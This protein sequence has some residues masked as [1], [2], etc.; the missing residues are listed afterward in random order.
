MVRRFFRILV[1]GYS[2]R[3]EAEEVLAEFRSLGYRGAFAAEKTDTSGHFQSNGFDFTHIMSNQEFESTRVS[4]DEVQSFLEEKDS[5]LADYSLDGKPFS[6]RL[7]ELSR[8]H[9]VNPIVLLAQLQKESSLVARKSPPSD[10]LLRKAMGYAYTDSGSRP[11][12]SSFSW[13]LEQAAR[14]LR[15]RFDEGREL[16]FPIQKRVDYGTHT[17]EVDNAASYALL[18]Y[19]PHTRDTKLDQVGGGNHNFRRLYDEF[20]S[21]FRASGFLRCR[22]SR[23]SG[24]IPI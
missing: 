11:T 23:L 2:S 17:I 7:V 21:E 19:T 16:S 6:T 20:S 10:K 8:E 14:N 12:H 3:N 5:F 18:T 24:R 13:Q 9:R 22:L 15:K 1:D 4:V